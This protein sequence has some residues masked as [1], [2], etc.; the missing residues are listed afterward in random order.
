[1]GRAF[2]DRVAGVLGLLVVAL[3]VGA[4]LDRVVVRWAL[5][6]VDQSFDAANN[7][8]PAGAEPPANEA[9]YAPWGVTG[10]VRRVRGATHPF[11]PWSALQTTLQLA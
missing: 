6:T 9:G 2:P 3:V 5:A 4:V 7:V 1:L 10:L 11:T 8:V